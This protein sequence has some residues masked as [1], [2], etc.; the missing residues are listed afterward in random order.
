MRRPA[1][2]IFAAFFTSCLVVCA[3]VYLFRDAVASGLVGRALTSAQVHCNK[4]GVKV[5]AALDRIT[6]GELSCSVDMGPI[7]Y[8]STHGDTVVSL[9]HFRHATVHIEK[10]TLD[11]RERD[12]SYVAT[13]SRGDLSKI[14]GMSEPLLKGM[15]DASELYSPRAPALAIKELTLSRGGRAEAVLHDFRK[16][17]HGGKWDRSRAER[18]EL[19]GYAGEVA[20][21]ELDLRVTPTDGTIAGSLRYGPPPRGFSIFV[22]GQG[23]DRNRPHFSVKL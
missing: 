5:S 2:H 11:Q 16:A 21:H 1:R 8:A 14:N 18:V 22:E 9:V 6:V 4:P 20:L 15:L 7:R 3:V 17:M 19:L 23:L 12:V 10:V 13:D